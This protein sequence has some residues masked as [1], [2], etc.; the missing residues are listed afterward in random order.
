MKKTRFLVSI[1]LASLTLVGCKNNSSTD[2]TPDPIPE[3]T[4]EPSPEPEPTPEPE[5]E[6]E[7]NPDP[8]PDPGTDEG[9]KP[10][11]M[12]YTYMD[13]ANNFYKQS[14]VIPNSGEPKILVFPVY[15]NNSN[16]YIHEDKKEL[17][18][19]DIEKCFFG[20]IRK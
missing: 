5:P 12:N 7:P 3:P 18:K 2:P 4:P 11:K 19:N 9:I 1:L 14:S 6:P 15:F 13:Y 8:N 10:T 17:V 20:T 16:E